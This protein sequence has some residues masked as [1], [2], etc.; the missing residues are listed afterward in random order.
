MLPPNDS[1]ATASPF[2][3]GSSPVLSSKIAF[4]VANAGWVENIDSSRLT[5][6]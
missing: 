1:S 6:D 4:G 3:S 2:V 5:P